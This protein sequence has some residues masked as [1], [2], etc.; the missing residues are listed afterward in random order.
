MRTHYNGSVNSDCIGQTISVCG[1]VHR[2]RDL[3]GV[4]FVNL[5]D[6][7]GLL[8]IV[9][10]QADQM[11]LNQANQLKHEDVVQIT[12]IVRQRPEG[13]TNES[14]ASGAIE[15]SV[16][17]LKV[18][19]QADPIPFQLDSQYH[20][21]EDVRLRYRYIDLRR[22]EMQHHFLKR[23]QV[24]QAIRRYLDDQGFL[25]I[26]TPV[27]TKATPE[28]ARDYLVPSRNFK[29]RFYA[30]PQSPQLFKQLL[31]VSGFDR[32]YQIVKCFRDEDLRADRQPEFTQVDIEASFID[33]PMLMQMMES[34]IA[35]VF[36]RVNGVTLKTPFQQLTYAQ[37]IQQYGSDKPDLRNPLYFVDIEKLMAN[38]SFSVFA[39]SANDPDSRLVAMRLPQGATISRKQID[40]YT[41]FVKGYGAKGLAY[42]KVNDH[43]A[44]KDGLQSPIVKHLSASCLNEL[45][46]TTQA[47]TGDL[48]FF[49]A[50]SRKVVNDAM[51]AL[52][53]QL[54]KDFNLY[55]HD[56]A[57]LWVT[58]FPMF[59]KDSNGALTPLH[60][61][62]TAPQ[63][64]TVDQLDNADMTQMLSRA[65]DMVI[66]GY[67][68]GGGSIRIHDTK[69]QSKI[70]ELLGI[71]QAEA[72]QKFGFFLEALRYGTPVHGGI[73]FGL[74]R[75][76]MLLSGAE[77]IRDVIAFPKTLAASC[78]MTQAPTNIDQAQLDELGIAVQQKD[79]N[80]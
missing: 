53:D 62:F 66:N 43:M 36:E 58:D 21:S 64:D 76:C 70:F 67:E 59:E 42:I 29:G 41:E 60:H 37:A 49:G 23:A 10:D 79:K 16:T 80:N 54:G 25:D 73:A 17:K 40:S 52:R 77:S 48:I 34:M 56:W 46:T 50:G 69:V 9:F 68:V 39:D 47:E 18:L 33:E 75:L 6:R 45:I 14:L 72:E 2:R 32:Y 55:T 7:S 57:P 20:V 11:I 22:Y 74:D 35:G 19:S 51:G 78:L 8:Q 4:I 24:T 71:S 65:Y 3:G 44:G 30:L 1:W 27:L 61:P 12:G 28:G 63:V 31:M 5:R 26:E 38:E 15:L 13:Q